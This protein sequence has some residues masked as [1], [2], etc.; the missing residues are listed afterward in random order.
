MLQTLGRSTSWRFNL[1]VSLLSNVIILSNVIYHW[2]WEI[3]H[4]ILSHNGKYL[5]KGKWKEAHY[6]V[7]QV[8]FRLCCHLRDGYKEIKFLFYFLFIHSGF[9]WAGVKIRENHTCILLW[10]VK[11]RWWS[12]GFFVF[13]CSHSLT[14]L[15]NIYWGLGNPHLVRVDDFELA[16]VPSLGARST[17]QTLASGRELRESVEQQLLQVQ[18]WGCADVAS[19]R[20]LV[21]SRVLGLP[22]Q[23]EEGSAEGGRGRRPVQVLRRRFTVYSSTCVPAP[24]CCCCC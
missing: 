16:T 22:S 4:L 21:W 2:Y 18:G 13:I 3:N 1:C 23:G 12:V 10:I 5:G 11:S 14:H 7:I 6:Q 8:K 9:E 20:Q 15:A 24:F 19:R 17:R